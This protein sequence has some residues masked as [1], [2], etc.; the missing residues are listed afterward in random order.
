MSIPRHAIILYGNMHMECREDNVSDLEQ[1]T[2][3]L[4]PLKQ[5]T[6]DSVP[7]CASHLLM[8]SSKSPLRR[9]GA[10]RAEWA[11]RSGA[12]RTN[13][14]NGWITHYKRRQSQRRQGTYAHPPRYLPK[15][16]S[17]LMLTCTLFK[18]IERFVNIS[19]K[20]ELLALRQNE[21]LFQKLSP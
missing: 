16:C 2:H 9:R 7:L 3:I 11:H 18:I 14:R 4:D 21:R 5:A 12:D 15:N 1:S 17:K 20:I 19:I 10:G 8:T 6:K 13:P